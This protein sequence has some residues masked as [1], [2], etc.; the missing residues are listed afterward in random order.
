VSARPVA[1]GARLARPVKDRAALQQAETGLGSPRTACLRSDS[2][3]AA[4]DVFE[5][6]TAAV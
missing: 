3:T 5:R 1:A 2:G 4:A 6:A